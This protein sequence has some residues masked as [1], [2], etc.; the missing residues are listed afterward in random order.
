[1]VAEAAEAKALNTA[2]AVQSIELKVAD[3]RAE[4]GRV[5]AARGEASD[6]DL[7]LAGEPND[8]I[9]ALVVG[10]AGEGGVEIEGDRGALDALRAIVVLPDRLRREAEASLAVA[11]AA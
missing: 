1:L 6:P 10:E 4:A 8:V 2:E 5:E 3:L 7:T 11:P 9:A